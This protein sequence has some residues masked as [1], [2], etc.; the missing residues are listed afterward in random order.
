M[1]RSDLTLADEL[2]DYEEK[3]GV[4]YLGNPEDIREFLHDSIDKMFATIYGHR[5]M[6]RTEKVQSILLGNTSLDDTIYPEGKEDEE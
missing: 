6:L 3:P 1:A 5:N 2:N 4:I